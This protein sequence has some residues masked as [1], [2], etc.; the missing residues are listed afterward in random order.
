MIFIIFFIIFIVFIHYLT[1]VCMGSSI[2][3]YD[4][5]IGISAEWYGETKISQSEFWEKEMP[6]LSASI[7]LP[8][9]AYH[10]ALSA[11]LLVAAFIL[12][13]IWK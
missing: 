8:L 12:F 6:F 10:P 2:C 4:S 1:D 11:S 5:E 13:Y 7:A 3:V 9:L